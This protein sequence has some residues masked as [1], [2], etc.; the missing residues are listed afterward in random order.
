MNIP[1]A[2]LVEIKTLDQREELSNAIFALKCFAVFLSPI[3]C[4]REPSPY[5][6]SLGTNKMH[7]LKGVNVVIKDFF[8]RAH[9]GTLICR[10][11]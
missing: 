10:T 2:A 4:M 1:L 5:L 6:V 8:I 11:V 7:S 9:F 3:T